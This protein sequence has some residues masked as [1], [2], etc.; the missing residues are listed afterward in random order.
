MRVLRVNIPK[1]A[2]EN[3]LIKVVKYIIMSINDEHIKSAEQLIK[4]ELGGCN[5]LN[6]IKI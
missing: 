1:V 6:C 5:F 3:T 2:L 4:G